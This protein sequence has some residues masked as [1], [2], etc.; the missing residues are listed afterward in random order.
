MQTSR[1]FGYACNGFR[2]KFDLGIRPVQSRWLCHV[3]AEPRPPRASLRGIVLDS[4]MPFCR[5]SAPTTA[6]TPTEDLG[7]GLKGSSV[8]LLVWRH[9]NPGS[10]SC[11]S[12][13]VEAWAD[14]VPFC[15]TWLW[16]PTCSSIL[17]HCSGV[18]CSG[19]G[20][21]SRSGHKRRMLTFGSIKRVN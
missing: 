21:A 14:P 20:S 4:A 3:T 1:P 5:T 18:P 8:T 12:A 11:L 19:I 2:Y 13:E 17:W 10:K 16:K 9:C 6:G 15:A 7:I